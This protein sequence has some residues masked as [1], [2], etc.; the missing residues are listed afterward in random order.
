MNEREAA[1]MSDSDQAQEISIRIP[2]NQLTLWDRNPRIEQS[3]DRQPQAIIAQ[4]LND[5]FDPIEIGKNIALA[6]WTPVSTLLVTKDG[7][8]DGKFTVVEGNRRL[9]AL[10]ALTDLELR[11]AMSNAEEWHKVAEKARSLGN[12]PESVPCVV[13]ATLSEAKKKL[14]SIHILGIKQWGPFQKDRFVVENIDAGD[15]I[16]EVAGSFGFDD[17]DVR[18]SVLVFRVFKSLESSAYGQLLPRH[19]G[20]LRELI[21][22]YGAIRN[23]MGLPEARQVDE[24]FSG[25]SPSQSEGVAEILTWVFGTSPDRGEDPDEGRKVV[26][27]REYRMLNRVVQ[28]VRGLEALR[29]E[30]TTLREA[31]D[32]VLA[33]G[34]D[35]A[36][37]FEKNAK[38]L[39]DA[40][41]RMR[42]IYRNE[43][44]EVVSDVSKQLLTD[45]FELVGSVTGRI[46][47]AS[48]TTANDEDSG[49][50]QSDVDSR[51]SP[52]T[53]AP[54]RDTWAVW[55]GD[56]LD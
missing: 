13:V 54:A 27:T 46:S 55:L 5:A 8:P 34:A 16:S 47:G 20:N 10:L 29:N 41:I 51:Q 52:S 3:L 50:V 39:V 45:A 4:A 35:P 23:M 18:K 43:G 56:W 24:S 48:G 7:A 19:Y 36:V 11:S 53:G 33:E 25:L 32:I 15:P 26:E 12:L 37:E 31:Y 44:P 2:I 49:D 17:V 9:T 38:L 6:G 1:S 42:E 22:K 14:G 28:S 40:L 30:G 21:L